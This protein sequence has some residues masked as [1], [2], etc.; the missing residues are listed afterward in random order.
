MY[1]YIFTLSKVCLMT[2]LHVT[3]LPLFSVLFLER[4]NLSH[5]LP[6]TPPQSF[7]YSLQWGSKIL[8]TTSHYCDNRA[9]ETLVIL[10]FYLGQTSYVVAQP[11]TV[12]VLVFVICRSLLVSWKKMKRVHSWTHGCWMPEQGHTERPTLGLEKV[13]EQAGMGR[14]WE[15]QNYLCSSRHSSI[16]NM[17]W[18]LNNNGNL[19]HYEALYSCTYAFSFTQR[20]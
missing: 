3:G 7:S 9:G 1:V 16:L 12:I 18:F 6:P 20:K 4:T 17:Y 5:P 19:S 11:Q 10:T 8:Y 14:G 2:Y 13:H 15:K